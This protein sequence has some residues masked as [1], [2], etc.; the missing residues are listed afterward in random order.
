MAQSDLIEETEPDRVTAYVPKDI[1][2]LVRQVRAVLETR[3][4]APASVADDLTIALTEALNNVA[5]HAYE[6]R[7]G[8]VELSIEPVSSGLRLTIWDEGR[9][10]PGGRAPKGRLP[11][12]D[13]AVASLPEGG[14]GWFLLR[15]LASRVGYRRHAGRNRLTLTFLF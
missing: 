7:P 2:C 10:M 4:Q 14:F 5:E 13:G 3:L 1:P 15:R 8:K 11:A 6:H 9:A 12:R